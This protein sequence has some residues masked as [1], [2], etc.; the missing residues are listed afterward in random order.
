M[1]VPHG[2]SSHRFEPI[3]PN[4]KMSTMPSAALDRRRQNIFR[5]S[6]LDLLPPE[7]SAIAYFLGA[8]KRISKLLSASR[9]PEVLS[10]SR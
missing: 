8:A 6:P 4:K 2:E 1:P 10:W 7:P 9:R 3:H 5:R